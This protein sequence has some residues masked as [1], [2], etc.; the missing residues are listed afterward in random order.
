MYNLHATHCVHVHVVC[1]QYSTAN[2]E[3]IQY[4]D[5]VTP[6]DEE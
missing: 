6:F 5:N 1:W 3:A 4:K 2:G